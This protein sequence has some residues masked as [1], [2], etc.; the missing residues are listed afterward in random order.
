MAVSEATFWWLVG[1]GVAA[2]S[3]L[4]AAVYAN[5]RKLNKLYQ[6]LFGMDADETDEGYMV[7][8]DAKLD[9]LHDQMDRQ[10]NEVY[11]KLRE[12]NGEYDL[13]TDGDG[14]ESEE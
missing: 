5:R 12:I 7:R 11:E 9:R 3:T 13:R 8:M 6:R 14:Y 10:H 1:G 2:L 4:S